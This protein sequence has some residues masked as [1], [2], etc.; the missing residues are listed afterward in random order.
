MIE[1]QRAIVVGGSSGIGAE[2]VRL[3][4]ERGCKVAAVARR[5]ERLEALEKSGHGAVL[6][7]VHDVK[8]AD[9]VPALFLEITKALG[10]LDLIVYAAG[11][12]PDVAPYEYSFAKDKEIIEVNLL[13]CIAWMNQAAVRFN[14]TGEGTMVAIGSVAGDRGRAGQPVYNT[15]KAAV[16]TYMEALR[17]R[18]AKSGVKVVTI[19]PGPTAT[20][21]TERSHMRGLMDVR[22]V[23]ETILAKS[24]KTGEH[25]VKFG[26][27]LAFY[28]I[29]RI[30]SPIFR[31]LKI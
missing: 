25:Y 21:M 9:E 31:K 27:R 26:H 15:S 16:A 11:V 30:P 14:N 29:K 5:K 1:Y 10:G 4:S 17:N 18:L 23:A 6:P 20:E 7:F 19:K 8:N 22:K 24:E 3:L 28:V 12:M 2:I 13:G